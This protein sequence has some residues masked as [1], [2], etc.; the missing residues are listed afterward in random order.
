[1][2]RTPYFPA[3]LAVLCSSQYTLR[4]FPFALCAL[5][6]PLLLAAFVAQQVL[7]TKSA[8]TM[9]LNVPPPPSLL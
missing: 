2:A 4:S 9:K 5:P 3:G 7:K 6:F 8:S 1:V